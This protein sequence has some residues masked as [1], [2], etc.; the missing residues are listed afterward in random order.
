M[1]D[2]LPTSS[3]PSALGVGLRWEAASESSRGNSVEKTRRK[4]HWLFPKTKKKTPEK[5]LPI[6][7]QEPTGGDKSHIYVLHA[8]KLLLTPVAETSH[9]DDTICE[10]ISR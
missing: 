4:V 2:K 1:S 6:L 7:G 10:H 5:D 8:D 3:S 9:Q